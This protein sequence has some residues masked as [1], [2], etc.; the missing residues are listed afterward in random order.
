MFLLGCIL[1]S[2]LAI[3]GKVVAEF[4][5]SGPSHWTLQKV[6]FRVFQ[7][8]YVLVTLGVVGTAVWI[9]T[10]KA[11]TNKVVSRRIM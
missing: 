4:W 9:F 11:T 10:A 7:G 3:C 5:R 2:L 1:T 8:S 6:A